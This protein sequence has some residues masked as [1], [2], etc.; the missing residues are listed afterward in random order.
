MTN[1]VY[2]HNVVLTDSAQLYSR[3][4]TQPVVD[5]T[6]YALPTCS[7]GTL[8]YRPVL[9]ALYQ[10]VLMA[11]YW[12]VLMIL[13]QPCLAHELFMKIHTVNL[14]GRRY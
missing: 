10:P 7:D 13:Y 11:L 1:P 6:D 2:M 9:M 5:I 8:P 14:I 12:P 4:C 3:I